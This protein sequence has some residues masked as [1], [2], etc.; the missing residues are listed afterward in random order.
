MNKSFTVTVEIT[1]LEIAALK[2]LWPILILIPRV[3]EK[4]RVT[5]IY[6]SLI[7]KGLAIEKRGVLHLTVMGVWVRLQIVNSGE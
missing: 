7:Q 2:G 3:S 1:P 4:N 5:K 6:N